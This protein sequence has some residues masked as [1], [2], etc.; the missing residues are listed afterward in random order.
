MP[1]PCRHFRPAS[2]TLHFELSTITGTRAMSGSAAI[3]CRNSH[4]RLFGIEHALVHV[5]VEHLRAA[6]DLLAR[7]GDRFVVAAFQDQ[8]LELRRAGDVGALADVDEVAFRRDLQR[9]EAAEPGLARESA[10]AASA[11]RGTARVAAGRARPR[12]SRAMCAGRR[13]AAAADEVQQAG[14][15]ELAQH[16]R[17]VLRRFV[18]AAEGVGQA[19]VRMRADVDVGDLREDV[20]VRRAGPSRRARSSGRST[21]AARGAAN[22]RTPRRSARTACGRRRR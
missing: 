15:G 16:A 21:A 18:V 10:H 9:L 19:G 12:R 20:D 6:F 17:H 4:H 2:I 8:L 22:T 3:R 1:L 5:D 7:D 14:F 13:A 11:S